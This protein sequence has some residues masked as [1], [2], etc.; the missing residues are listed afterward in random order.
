MTKSKISRQEI[1]EL[2]SALPPK[3]RRKLV[4]ELVDKMPPD[5]QIQLREDLDYQDDVKNEA[6]RAEIQ[7]GFDEI[8]QGHFFTGEEVIA[9][10]W[11]E[12]EARERKAK[13][14]HEVV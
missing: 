14:S 3:E 7:R 6:L 5:E 10:L 11:Q 1:L 9:E 13:G 4:E 12:Q 2:C 8:D